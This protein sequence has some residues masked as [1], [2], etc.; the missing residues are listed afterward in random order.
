[1]KNPEE[2]E[3]VRG[4][5]RAIRYLVPA[6][7]TE[8]MTGFH[9]GNSNSAVRKQQIPVF[10]GLPKT[11]ATVTGRLET[12]SAAYLE[13]DVERTEVAA[14]G[15]NPATDDISPMSAD[16]IMTASSFDISHGIHDD[17]VHNSPISPLPSSIPTRQLVGNIPLHTCPDLTTDDKIAHAFNNSTRKTLSYV[18]LTIQNGEVVVR[19]TLATI[20]KDPLDGKLQQLFKTVAHMEEVI[21]GG[22][23]LFQGQPIVLQKWAP[24]MEMRKLKHTQVLEG[25]S[26]VAR[27]IGKPLYPNTITRACTRLDFARVCVM[28]NVNSIIRKHIII[29]TPDEEGGETPCKIDVEYKW[30]PPKC[31]SCKT[32]G[33]A[34]KECALNKSSKPVKPPVSVYIPKTGPSRPTPMPDR[35][36]PRP[37]PAREVEKYRKGIESSITVAGPSHEERAWDENFIDVDVVECGTQFIHC[38]VNIRALHETIAI[39]VIY[40]ANEIAE[41]RELWIS[42]ETIA[43]QCNDIPWLVGGDINAVRD[44]SKICGTAGDTRMAMEEFNSCI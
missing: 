30:L 29:M 20:R 9:G 19:P 25:L 17:V 3:L 12:M 4:L 15:V 32:L 36:T 39:T 35:I 11:A 40:E 33:H 16:E 28:I 6:S 42:V 41:R 31:T 27:G 44:T 13:S 18:A 8:G 1:M 23:W 21:E 10:D 5:R 14:A 22:A 24:G 34:A 26:I 2:P 43:L 7:R 37:P 38:R